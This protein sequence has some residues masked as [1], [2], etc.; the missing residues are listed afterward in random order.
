MAVA[1]RGIK[2]VR[3]LLGNHVKWC[4]NKTVHHFAAACCSFAKNTAFYTRL[5]TAKQIQSRL[6]AAAYKNEKQKK[7]VYHRDMRRQIP[8]G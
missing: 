8:C 1:K 3:F 7:P 5:L 4:Y 2:M 6:L